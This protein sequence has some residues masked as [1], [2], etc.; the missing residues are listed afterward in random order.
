M[1]HNRICSFTIN[2]FK[3]TPVIG[4][5]LL[6]LFLDMYVFLITCHLFCFIAISQLSVWE[7]LLTC[8]SF[9]FHTQLSSCE[10]PFPLSH[11]KISLSLFYISKYD[12]VS[13]Y[14]VPHCLISL[15]FLCSSFSLLTITIS[16]P[17]PLLFFVPPFSTLPIFHLWPASTN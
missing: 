6:S 5:F 17:D 16:L 4:I 7:L 12:S 9:H 13:I 3:A 11:P 8:S 15:S 10:P 14:H 1:S 2:V